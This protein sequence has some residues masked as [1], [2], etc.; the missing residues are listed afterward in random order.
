MSLEKPNLYEITN[1]RL[2]ILAMIEKNDG[3]VS[4][5]LVGSLDRIDGE[6]H[7]KVDAIRQVISMCDSTV[8]YHAG[9]SARHRDRAAAVRKL[10]DRLEEW[11][12][13]GMERTG[14][15]RAGRVIPQ[16]I[17]ANGG[18]PSIKWERIGEPI[19][20][21]MVRET[22]ELDPDI[23]YAY[24][25]AGVLPE[26]FSVTKGRHLR[27]VF[28]EKRSKPKKIEGSGDDGPMGIRD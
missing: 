9:E 7:S 4:D 22:R 18:R 5:E 27:D 13:Q 19:P 24:W 16:R 10:R 15:E 17:Q 3:E 21:D 12:I 1:A 25:K 14:I 8:G 6:F 23:A 2:V 11:V 20:E 26:G 28:G